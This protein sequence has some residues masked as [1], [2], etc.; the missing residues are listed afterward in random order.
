MHKLLIT[1]VLLTLGCFTSQAQVAPPKTH[2]LNLTE[3][4]LHWKGSY[5]FNISEHNGEVYFKEG[6]LTTVG[7]KIIGGSFIIDMESMTNEEYK[8]DKEHGPVGHLKHADFFDVTRFPEAKLEI[9]TIEY[10]PNTNTHEV[11]ADLTVKGIKKRIK[12][13]AD[14]DGPKKTMKA[15][16]KIDRTRWGITYNN[17]VKERAISDAIEFKA[18]L[19]F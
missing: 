3:S 7:D 9:V 4:V 11:Y 5:T 17:E 19:Q 12:F 14:V 10:F 1:L 8:E 6:A 13:Y 18:D 16:F 15:H 2:K